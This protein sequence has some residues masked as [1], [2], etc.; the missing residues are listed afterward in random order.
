MKGPQLVMMRN[1][2]M[3]MTPLH[4]MQIIIPPPWR[5]KKGHSSPLMMGGKEAQAHWRD[6]GQRKIMI[7]CL[8]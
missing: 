6:I 3:S 2:G 1:Q 5:K 7:L 8:E 4:R